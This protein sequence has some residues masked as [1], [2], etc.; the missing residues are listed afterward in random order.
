MLFLFTCKYSTTVNCIL[1]INN[2]FPAISYIFSTKLLD[3]GNVINNHHVS[4]ELKIMCF[5]TITLL[6]IHLNL[7]INIQKSI[8][9]LFTDNKQNMSTD[10]SCI[11][12]VLFDTCIFNVVECVHEYCTNIFFTS[13]RH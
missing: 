3:H 4:N 2:K 12:N 1:Q 5:T 11:K 7:N 9:S 13:K 10:T 8:K 6:F